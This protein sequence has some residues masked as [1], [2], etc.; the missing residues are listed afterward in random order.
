MEYFSFPFY[1][2]QPF[3]R[4]M[5]LMEGFSEWLLLETDGGQLDA[6]RLTNGLPDWQTDWLAGW[7]G[8]IAS[9]GYD[10]FT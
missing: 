10:I 5:K 4:A 9:S 6:F 7:L 1:G 3:S 2:Q 8:A